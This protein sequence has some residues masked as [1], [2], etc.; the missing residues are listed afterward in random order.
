MLTTIITFFA[1]VIL[2]IA[3]TFSL[4]GNIF[5][6][7][8]GIMSKNK[9]KTSEIFQPNPFYVLMYIVSFVEYL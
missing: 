3:H 2:L 7:L 1:V 4:R 8:F 5:I 6:G 9:H